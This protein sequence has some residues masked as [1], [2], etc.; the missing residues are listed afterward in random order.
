MRPWQAEIKP[1]MVAAL[2]RHLSTLLRA[3]LRLEESLNVLIEQSDAPRVVRVL[4]EVRGRVVEGQTFAGALDTF[5][6]SFPDFYRRMI[7]SGE[8]SGRL[9]EVLERLAV[10]MERRQDLAQKVFLAMVY[11]A[12][13]TLVALAV[14]TGLMTYVVPQVTR[15]F[16]GSGQALPFATRA[17]LAFSRGFRAVAPIAL[18]ACAM[19][20]FGL[21]LGARRPAVR[22]KLDGWIL[23]AGP[24]GRFARDVD[25]ARFSSALAILVKSGIP[26][27]NSLETASA[28][29]GN[30]ILRAAISAAAKRVL[31]GGTLASAIGESKRFPPMLVH[32]VA[33]GEATGGLGDMLEQA[34]LAQ[35]AELNG[36]I[37]V[38]VALVEPILILTM[39]GIV[40]FIVLAIL[41]PIIQMNQLIK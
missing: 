41:S 16:L 12:L 14:V 21:A 17:L 37:S 30:R 36:R 2:T 35:A 4:A 39:G 28:L 8:R 15:V 38:C 31:E 29:V 11:P 19:L 7:E 27:I 20:V 9:D 3:G 18:P 25:V 10:Y 13:V 6:R 40:L 33:N 24:L 26:L 22:W 23:K 32:L 34:A 1:I 5:P